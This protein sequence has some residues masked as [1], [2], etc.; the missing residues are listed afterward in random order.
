MPVAAWLFM[1]NLH[2][3]VVSA[4]MTGGRTA[5]QVPLGS[6]RGPRACAEW[7]AWLQYKGWTQ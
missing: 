4:E 7:L 1:F 5:G 2:G 3:N 6:C